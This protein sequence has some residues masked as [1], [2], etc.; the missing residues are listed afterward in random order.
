MRTRTTR[1]TTSPLKRDLEKRLEKEVR[2]A[3]DANCFAL[4]AAVDG[5]GRG[6]GVVFGAILGT[7]VG[8][9][10][11]I[12]QRV[13]AGRHGIA[14]EWGHTPLPRMTEDEY[15]GPRCTCGRLGEIG[16]SF[17]S[18]PRNARGRGVVRVGEWW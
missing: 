11:A 9:G 5:A 12:H 18:V 15:P 6:A 10:I 7:G 4:S 2:F 8:G 3:N 13:I 1:R 16:N 14:G 17:A